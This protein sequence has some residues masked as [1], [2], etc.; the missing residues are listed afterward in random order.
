MIKKAKVNWIEKFRLEG[1]TD[2]GKT[3]LMDSGENTIAAS[4]AQLLLQALA[5]CTM[6]DCVLIF[7]KARKHLEK[8]WID[9]EAD[10]MEAFPKAY[11]KIHL[12]YHI[13]S[14]DI[15]AEDAERAI[16]LSEEKYCRVHY[17]LSGKV[18]LS[19]SFVIEAES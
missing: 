1:Q 4:P 10:E 13:V 17:M 3:V 15:T 18:E 11:G 5:G 19:S 16:K 14:N 6:M 2:N 9:V 7:T 8:F 12:T